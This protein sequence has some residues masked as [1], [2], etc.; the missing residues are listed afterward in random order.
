VT[1]NIL[2]VNANTLGG[3][4]DHYDGF[5]FFANA[6]LGRGFLLS[7]GVSAGR[8]RTDSCAFANNLAVTFQTGVTALSS[9]TGAANTF[10]PRT[11]AFCDVIPPFQPLV[12][13]QIV[14]PFPWGIQASATFQ[15]LPGPQLSAQEALNN[16]IAAPSLGRNFST[17]APSVDLIAPGTLYGDRIF[18][19]DLRFS[20][21]VKWGRTIVRPTVSVYNL[22]NANPIQ[23]YNT[24]YNA[25]NTTS[26]LGP[27][28]I[29][30]P[31]FVDFGV[32][33]TF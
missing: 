32:Q 5:D 2:V 17:V 27:S 33:L 16:A 13:G 9:V 12:K 25:A 1:N 6:R 4:Q 30:T 23:T 10:S 26:F 24:T 15:S 21:S 29:L 31:R 8:E 22:F 28:V 14:Y 3:I 7:G 19:T 18:Q 11:T 20:K